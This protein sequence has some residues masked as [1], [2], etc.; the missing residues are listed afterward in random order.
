VP[1]GTAAG[2][3]AAKGDKTKKQLSPRV[4]QTNGGKDVNQFPTQKGAE[5]GGGIDEEVPLFAWGTGIEKT[6]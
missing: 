4:M 3:P 6:E 1:K 5:R 2:S